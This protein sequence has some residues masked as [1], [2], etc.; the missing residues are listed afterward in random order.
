MFHSSGRTTAASG[1]AEKFQTET[2]DNFT[3]DNA[4]VYFAITDRF[5]NGDVTNDHS[6][7]RSI[8]EVDAENYQSRKGTF[9]GGDLTGLTKKIEEGYF[10]ELG[11]NAIWFT[12]PYEQIHG[13]LCG[14]GFKYYAY[15]GYYPLD[16]TNM[17]ANMGTEDD[18]RKF[19]NTAHE[20]GIRVVM[21]VVLNHVGYADPVTATEYGFGELTEN[22]EEIYYNTS[23]LEYVWS[24]DYTSETTN[25]I[26]TLVSE[27]DWTGWWG[28][29]WIRAITG[30]YNGYTGSQ[31]DSNYKLCLGG[32]PDVKTEDTEDNS[33][34]P[35][36]Q[37][38]WLKE[39][40]LQ[41]EEQSL[42]E[43]FEKSGLPRKNVNYIIKW[44]T[45]Y[46]RE[47]GIDGFRCDS[48]KHVEMEHWGVLK[49]QA[50]IALKEWR[51]QNPANIAATWDED[52]WMVGENFDFNNKKDS[53]FTIGGFDAM[54]N[55]QFQG[56]EYNPGVSLEYAYS[57]YAKLITTEENFNM[58]SYISSHDTGLGNR[59]MNGGTA[60][61]LCPGAVQIYYGDES[62]R[63]TNGITGEQGWRTQ[64]NWDSMDEAVLEHYKKLGNFRKN[65][66]AVAKGE[67]EKISS[68][69]YTFSRIYEEDKVVIC[70]PEKAGEYTVKVGTVFEEG[71]WITDVYT[72]KSYQ[73]SAGSI[74]VTC[75]NSAP[76]LL[77]GTGK[78]T[79]CVGAKLLYSLL[80][81]TSETIQIQLYATK[82][83]DTKYSVNDGASKKFQNGMQITIGGGAA[84]GEI[85]KLTLMGTDENGE[86]IEREYAYAKC[87]EPEV[88]VDRFVISV[89]KEEFATAPYCYVYEDSTVYTNN[90]PG[91]LMTDDGEYWTFRSNSMDSAYVILSLG[92]N[93]EEWRST[94]DL[95]PG[96][97]VS[98]QMIYNK[99]TGSLME[100]PAEKIG[101][102]TVNY[103]S[104]DGEILKSVVRKGYVGNEYET[105]AA[106]IAE[107]RLV[108]EP[109]N[110]SGYFTEE[111]IEVTYTYRSYA[112]YLTP[113]VTPTSEPKP[114]VT[115]NVSPTA[116]I[117]PA[118]TI[119]V[120]PTAAPTV[121]P[122]EPST[123]PVATSVPTVTVMVEKTPTPVLSNTVTPTILPEPTKEII[124]TP[125]S[126]PEVTA[127]VTPTMT[128]VP[129]RIPTVT[130]T[131]IPTVVTETPVS[132]VTVTPTE[133]PD[134]SSP[135]VPEKI[136]TVTPT[137][138]I[139]QATTTPQPT[140]KA[141]K[142]TFKSSNK[143]IKLQSRSTKT[144][145]KIYT[146]KAIA[147]T[148]NQ[149]GNGK[150]YY[151]IVKKG[152][153]V[154]S[155]KWK[156]VK[157]QIVI[158]KDMKACVYVK[159][160]Q[161]EKTVIKKTK[162]FVFDK[163]AP[164][165]LVTKSRKLSVKDSGSGV[166]K[167][168]VDGKKVKNGVKLKK[169]IHKV[170]A[171]DK[172]GNKKALR[173]TVKH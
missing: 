172:V 136:V 141:G 19:V 162:G 63:T 84:Y 165:V 47:Y 13:A 67:H 30:R 87:G 166:K 25:G 27:G 160:T 139:K 159:Y 132:K 61:L 12:A 60:L 107:Y 158:K 163:T 20:H 4:T 109:A 106:T 122:L 104:A 40:R 171:Y 29:N 156:L 53:H 116:T 71:E 149:S 82:M 76:L 6:Y 41:K 42:D 62:G 15:H 99:E 108:S 90:Y 127:A 2:N 49:E 170:I 57:K 112:S 52:F 69:P 14:D 46:V 97:M 118:V 7:E 113:T 124:I 150:V 155:N 39:G 75:E 31:E 81:Y 117:V 22:W 89:S 38:K 44:L 5:V 26:A 147:L 98:G 37:N 130:P 115:P 131:I 161:N 168:M 68:S 96:I 103:K 55:L 65:H 151:Q 110:A 59:D 119:T 134:T 23:E 74:E 114:T 72:G 18:L 140:K 105:S 70:I 138:V 80:P 145:Y 9:H 45:D 35:L 101:T 48:V 148:L 143:K 86:Y 94:P 154:N 21:D 133:I 51:E 33:I 111:E 135:E 73:V 66:P 173:V 88:E 36:L 58:L 11:V 28:S 64:M 8:G 83:E 121:S 102:V 50:D 153:K 43:F 85:T 126:I 144:T 10:D 56:N 100:R 142:F 169:G 123:T 17:D 167:I 79:S 3:W 95:A 16:F 1:Q 129:T 54:V 92:D 78:V 32:L 120:S 34:P 93:G 146:N 152:S 137:A 77:E 128:V 24:M 125:T 164:K 157:N 91:N